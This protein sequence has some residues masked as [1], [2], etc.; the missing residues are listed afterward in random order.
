M[1]R[2]T[3]LAMLTAA[4]LPGLL[5]VTLALGG[6]PPT[7]RDIPSYFVPLRSY[8]AEVLTGRHDAFW[9]PRVGCGEPYFANPQANLLYPPAWLALLVPA[10]RAVGVEAGLHLALLGLGCAL[11]AR[12]LGARATFA[13]AAAW[14]A[15]LAGPLSDAVGVLNNLDTLA[16]A[17][18][19]WYAAL[20]GSLPATAGF[21]ALAYLGAEPQLTAVIGLI[22]LALAPR[23]TTLAALTLA[24]GLVA[25]QALPFAAWVCGGD[26]GP[27]Q[28]LD[29]V[30]AGALS[31]DDLL[32][33]I[34]PG[35]SSP[36]RSDR[37]VTVPAVPLWLLAFGL[38]AVLARDRRVRTLALAGWVLF[39]LAAIPG[40][41]WGRAPWAWFTA[42]LVHYPGRLLFPAVVAL[43]CAAA[44]AWRPGWRCLAGVAGAS[45]LAVAATLATSGSLPLLAGQVA[46]SMACASGP[47]APLAALAGAA[48]MTRSTVPN[49]TLH[50]AAEP[51]PVPCLAEQQ[52]AHG[53]VWAV[54]PSQE[55]LVWLQHGSPR[56]GE[57]L[58][59]GY[60]PLL[61]GRSV[62]RTFAPL[63]SRTLANH[64]A[65]ADRGPAGRWWL[66]ALAADVLVAHHEL[67]GFPVLCRSEGVVVCANPAAWPVASVVADMPTAGSLPVKAGEIV[68][69]EGRDDSLRWRL[70]VAD[71]GGLL[72]LSATPDPGWRFT[73]DGRPVA[74]RQ[75]PGILH[76]VAVAAGE[77]EV[78]ASYRPPG[79]LLGL[80]I[81][82]V[83]LIILVLAA[84]R[85]ARENRVSPRDAPRPLPS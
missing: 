80:A 71:G 33:M 72:L 48:L 30:C 62:A 63:Q 40:Q 29:A 2:R 74:V 43:A 17:P 9:T 47:L 85:R 19:V 44:A 45:T 54:Q 42:G 56:R 46:T 65:A 35:A 28:G 39:L 26:R 22:A 18:L 3:L 81:S 51:G 5:L 82:L 16:W 6:L 36:E 11:L 25:V 24:V 76:G 79:L 10:D 52:G 58:A 32:G 15:V 84:R 23:R 77:H 83:S 59:L 7:L 57:A 37:F 34:A 12:R 73:V 49:L 27:G 8:T 20:G 21:L 13:V 50:G 55:M 70:R 68:A 31:G 69:T 60:L 38:A 61:D 1:P 14:G 66:D 78:T 41:P 75:G 4:A 67:P 53:R 64:M